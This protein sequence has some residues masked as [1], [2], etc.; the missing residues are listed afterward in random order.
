MQPVETKTSTERTRRL[1]DE[2]REF[3]LSGNVG[4]YGRV[5]VTRGVSNRGEAF[6]RQTAE[7]VALFDAFDEGNDP[8]AEHDFGAFE[9]DEEKLFFKIDYYDLAMTGH[10]PDK[11]DV[12]VTNRVLT[13]MLASEY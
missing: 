12:G 2:M 3:M 11:S 5:I 4:A 13:I 7:A 6:V 1:N 8:H 10:S 9:I